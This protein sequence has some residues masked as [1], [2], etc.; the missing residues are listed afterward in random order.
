MKSLG[1]TARAARLNLGLT[2]AQAAQRAKLA[3]TV[4]GRI[5]R[6]GMMPSLP[7][8]LRLCNALGLDAN[9]L[10]GF[11]APQ[12]PSWFTAASPARDKP[13]VRDFLG[14]ARQLGPRQ[15]TALNILAQAML[16]PV[17]AP[18]L[19]VSASGEE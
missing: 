14:T 13:A 17:E 19:P 4:Y 12:P 15:L 8:L 9:G 2:Q 7:S 3:T 18:T 5:E 6:G 16:L 1:R 10:L 11:S